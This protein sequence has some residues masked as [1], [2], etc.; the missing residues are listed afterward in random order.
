MKVCKDKPS[1]VGEN[2]NPMTVISVPNPKRNPT[3]NNGVRLY[4]RR[5]C[6][7]SHNCQFLWLEVDSRPTSINEDFVDSSILS[8]FYYIF[9]ILHLHSPKLQL[10][11]IFEVDLTNS[12]LSLPLIWLEHSISVDAVQ[13]KPSMRGVDY[14]TVTFSSVTHSESNPT[15]NNGIWLNG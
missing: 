1:K 7:I 14:D 10:Q 6:L 4:G 3:F 9:L 5:Q 11:H 2:N 13:H 12:F 8:L 15:F